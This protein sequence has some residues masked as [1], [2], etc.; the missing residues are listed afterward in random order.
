LDREFKAANENPKLIAV[1]LF[2]KS[3]V[4]QNSS[5]DS[6]P[7]S[8]EGTLRAMEENELAFNTIAAT[9]SLT[10]DLKVITQPEQAQIFSKR[11][12]DPYVE[13]ND[14]STTTLLY[15]TKAIWVVKAVKDGCQPREVEFDPFREPIQ[16]LK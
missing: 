11:R 13:S 10:F 9:K 15:L 3:K 6:I 8:A 4:S 12:G 1:S 7:L 5:P 2:D 16:A 14:R